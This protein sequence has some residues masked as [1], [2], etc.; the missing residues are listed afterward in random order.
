M[1]VFRR[2]SIKLFFGGNPS[3][4][5]YWSFALTNQVDES[6]NGNHLGLNGSIP[7]VPGPSG[8]GRFISGAN[9]WYSAMDIGSTMSILVWVKLTSADALARIYARGPTTGCGPSSQNFNISPSN[10]GSS[11][12]CESQP[13]DSINCPL[14]KWVFAAFTVFVGVNGSKRYFNGKLTSAR[15]WGTT[16]SLGSGNNEIGAIWSG[17][18]HYWSTDAHFS[19]MALF[20]RILS[21]A[22]I[23]AYYKWAIGAKKGPKLVIEYT[24]PVKP[25]M[26]LVF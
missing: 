16:Q 9:N 2:G 12:G 13:A 25:G 11:V 26:L 5:G 19:E 17:N 22:E 18:V 10:I 14:N 20:D 7:R 15:D 23:S 1:A 24:A 21:P 8:G 6:G 3:L 4:K